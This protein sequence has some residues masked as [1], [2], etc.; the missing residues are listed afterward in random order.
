M[1]AILGFSGLLNE[2]ELSDDDKKTYLQLIHKNGEFLLKLINDI[3]DISKIESDQLT[4]IPEDFLLNELLFDIQIQYSDLIKSQTKMQIHFELQNTLPDGYLL[5][6]DK[7]RL[8]QV[9]DNL[10]GNA[11]KFTPEGTITLRVAKLGSWLHFN[12]QDTGIGIADE[13]I[14]NIFKRFTQA[15]THASETYGGTGLGLAISQKIVHLLGGDIGV[16]STQGKGSD[17]YFYIPG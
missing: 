13:D 15:R 6:T 4:I 2:Q 12:V 10:I 11:L 14:E 7:L 9:L 3:M 1:N 8:K 17:F 5:Q 16:K